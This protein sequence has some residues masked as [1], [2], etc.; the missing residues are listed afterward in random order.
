MKNVVKFL[1]DAHKC[2]PTHASSNSGRALPV[3]VV[4]VMLIIIYTNTVHNEKIYSSER[5][6]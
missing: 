6:V 5:Y 4:H 1:Q 3:T 2:A